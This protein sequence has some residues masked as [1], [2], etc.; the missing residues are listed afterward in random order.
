MVLL[1]CFVCVALPNTAI[2]DTSVGAHKHSYAVYT[3]AAAEQ[4]AHMSLFTLAQIIL[5]A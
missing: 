4:H 5:F 2:I 1:I 3:Q